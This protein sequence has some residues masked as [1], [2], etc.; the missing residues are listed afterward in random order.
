[1]LI[2][3]TNLR[4][5][6]NFE[7]IAKGSKYTF[8][9]IIGWRWQSN[10]YSHIYIYMPQVRCMEL[11]TISNTNLKKKSFCDGI[12]GKYLYKNKLLCFLLFKNVSLKVFN[13]KCKYIAFNVSF[14]KWQVSSKYT[15]SQYNLWKDS[16]PKTI[17]ECATGQIFMM[18]IR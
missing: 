6:W 1:M 8:I 12:Q 13:D 2:C 15:Q 10:F 5:V 11:F 3:Q 14:N 18:N 7:A 17:D 4:V 9:C 16:G